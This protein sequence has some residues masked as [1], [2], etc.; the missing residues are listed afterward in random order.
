MSEFVPAT[1]PSA[2]TGARARR[3][4]RSARARRR[5]GLAAALSAVL[6]AAGATPAF[7]HATLQSTTP[8]QGSRVAT[9][10]ASVSLHFSEAVGFN[11]R[12]IEVLDPAGRRV[13]R[14]S[15]YHPHGDG[16][17][18]AAD[19]RPGLP[20]A[21]Y[22]VVW[23]VVSADSHP[24]SGTFSFGLGVPAGSAP[25]TSAG[26]P[27]VQA[28]DAVFR[29]LG[30][31]G[32]VLLL[33]GLVF[34]LV[35]WPQGAAR[36]RARRLLVAG[37]AGSAISTLALYLLEGPYG[38]GLGL[39]DL[40]SGSLLAQTFATT[41]GKLLLLRLLVLGIAGS[42]ARA[43]Q[44][45]ER[46]DGDARAGSLPRLD[47]IVLAVL[48]VFSYAAAGH[49]GQGSWALLATLLDATHLVAAS[50]WLGG[51]AV[52]AY[53]VLPAEPRAVL[54]RVL[55]RWSRTAMI[56]VA[57]LVL[58]GSYQAW[59]EI[60]SV[61]ALLATGYGRLVLAK[62]AGLVLLLGLAELGRRWV[63]AHAGAA[64]CGPVTTVAAGIG[65]ARVVPAEAGP[66]GASTS[67]ATA[68]R[69]AA[70][71]TGSR[72]AGP[73]TRSRAAGPGTGSGATGPGGQPDQ[74]HGL[75]RSVAGEVALGAAVLVAT[76]LLVNSVP[77]V[78][79]YAP[80]YSATV[81]G[82]G[83]NGASIS[84]LIDVDSTRVGPTTLH[85][86]TYDRNGAVLPFVAADG[87]LAGR[88]GGLGPISFGFAP[89]GPGHGTA[90]GVVLPQAGRWTLNVQ[91]R[92]DATTD[93]SATTSF[94]VR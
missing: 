66:A 18:V 6:L 78:A 61:P 77:G 57:V 60:G 33:G 86:Y 9:E 74:L 64:A 4:A 67:A 44:E 88:P 71:G 10:P 34:L 62:V 69:A 32:T 5:L 79:A 92:T 24:I 30:Y 38:S 20:K 7:A 29:F 87:T 83:L 53:A 82:Q 90:P 12:S 11:D 48:L 56:A 52:L 26:D 84:V 17:T 21:S 63:R 76:A 89:T 73:G 54:L 50:T 14:G 8:S 47:L 49:A 23:H 16:S 27:T 85:L 58:T 80:P 65:L 35:L 28:L 55:P 25:A 81:V 36:P 37:W 39:G 93:Y 70:P 45:P 1:S 75:R 43:P 40:V 59:R 42:V 41:Y 15:V 68:T 46:R 72:A 51:L 31:L 2:P 94:S 13:D 19:L 91:I 22:A 3:R